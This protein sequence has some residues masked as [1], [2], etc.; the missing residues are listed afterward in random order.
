[1]P[2]TVRD[3]SG[4]VGSD[5]IAPPGRQQVAKSLPNLA[6]QRTIGSL[7][8]LGRPLAA[9]RQGVGEL[10]DHHV[11]RCPACRRRL[12][13]SFVFEVRHILRFLCTRCWATVHL[14]PVQFVACT[15]AGGLFG[16]G[17]PL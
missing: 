10:E 1:M 8:P 4:P 15:I 9:E 3:T 6:L 2:C 7:A 5:L 14:D 16:V 11:R 13:L 12:G 17:L